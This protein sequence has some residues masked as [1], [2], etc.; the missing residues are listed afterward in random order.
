MDDRPED[1]D[2]LEDID[3]S[4]ELPVMDGDVQVARAEGEEVDAEE[5]ATATTRSSSWSPANVRL[6]EAVQC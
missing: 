3:D 5:E 2:A 1:M 6:R 4:G